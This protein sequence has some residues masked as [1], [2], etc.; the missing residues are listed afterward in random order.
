MWKT[1]V[2]LEEDMEGMQRG[3]AATAHWA[4]FQISEGTRPRRAVLLLL[5]L[6]SRRGGVTLP[7]NENDEQKL[8]YG[9]R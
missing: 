8:H 2:A 1:E 5:S 7:Q 3:A 4:V 6:Q 9:D